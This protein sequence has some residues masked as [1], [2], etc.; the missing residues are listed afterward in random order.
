MRNVL[1]HGHIFKNA[2]TSLDWAL[3]RCFAKG[4]LN[5]V[6]ESLMR[7]AGSCHLVEVLDRSPAVQ[8]FS[9]HHMPHVAQSVPGY[10][11]F[12]LFL[13]RHPLRRCLSVYTFERR[14]QAQTRGALAAKDKTL[15]E[16]LAWRLEPDVPNVIRNYQTAYLAGDHRPLISEVDMAQR[17]VQAQERLGQLP[18]VGVVERYDE[19]MVVF[20]EALRPVFPAID[21]AYRIQNTSASDAES[22]TPQDVLDS[23]GNQAGELVDANA[24][25]TALYQ[26]ASLQLTKAIVAIDDFQQKLSDFS[27]RCNVLRYD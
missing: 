3:Q 14:Q 17:F 7:E 6:E 26:L 11:F 18:L 22:A 13:L 19:S 1:L 15:V 20:E 4:F 2:G 25:D 21:L 9:S 8:A 5:N 16:Y 12:P 23:M 27:N 24:Y 10:R